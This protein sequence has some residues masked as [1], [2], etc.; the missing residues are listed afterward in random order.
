MKKISKIW[1]GIGAA[2]LGIGI[3][4]LVIAL[5]MN[6]FDFSK[7]STVKYQTNTHEITQEF[8][9]ISLNT[10]TADIV[11]TQSENGKNE[12]VCVE[13]EN[14]KHSVLVENGTLSIQEKDEREW[15]EHIDFYSGQTKLTVCL[16]DVDY[17]NLLI[18]TSTGD[19]EIGENFSFKQAEI[20]A[21][22]GDVSWQA[23]VLESLKIKTSTGDICVKNTSVGR[24]DLSVS[25]GDIKVENAVVS[26][27]LR[28][29][30]DTGK[31]Q[32]I[33]VECENLITNGDTGDILLR[34]VIA[35][36]KM[37]IE[38]STGD[39]KFEKCDGAE[40]SI[41]TSTG[42]VKGTLTS[43][44]VF[45]IDTDTGEKSVPQTTTGG[46]CE[47]TTSTGDIILSIEK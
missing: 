13:K 18:K 28:A 7:F 5:A 27:E 35:S 19:L 41:K 6:G 20:T 1:L 4:A 38:R 14:L 45:I 9:K 17:E 30:V 46:R 42:D 8:D 31:T 33:S 34:N 47:I 39:I 37:T 15:Y 25:T 3:V 12:I 32:L 23:K 24:L 43:D 40:L 2:L 36:G 26:S 21:S 29:E 22:T 11:F 44:K 16:V 10:T